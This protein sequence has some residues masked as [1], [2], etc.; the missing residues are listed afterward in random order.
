MSK[1]RTKMITEIPLKAIV[2][3]SDG[4]CGEVATLVF[5]PLNRKLTNVIV[6]VDEMQYLVPIE[7]VVGSTPE[8]ITLDCTI[9]ELTKMELFTETRYIM[10]EMPMN[11]NPAY[12]GGMESSVYYMDPYVTMGQQV[13]VPTEILH[14]P[15]GQKAIFR[16]M[17]VQA[18]D[19]DVGQIGELVIDP[20]EGIITHFTLEQGHVLGTTAVTLPL[21]AVAKVG[22][23]VVFL[24]LSKADINKLPALPLKRSYGVTPEGETIEMVAIRFQTVDKAAEKLK[25]MQELHRRGTFKLINTA[26]FVRDEKGVLSIKESGDM[27][28][29]RGSVFGAITGGLM[30]MI[31]G[32]GGMVAGALVGAG[33]GRGAA[34]RID[35]G[36][37]DEFLKTLGEKLKPGQSAI[38][39]LLEHRWL[40]KYSEYMGDAEEVFTRQTLTDRMV[41]Q[42]LNPPAE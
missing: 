26:I 15:Q 20:K 34:K 33:V 27:G 10:T 38:L 3:C 25:E 7:K 29:K 4:E 14:I 18:T 13:E 8:R 42:L 17:E 16:G 35:V 37:N 2:D 1:E 39:V 21:A 28:P 19:G 31:A 22:S 12:Y 23:E 24:T 5:N 9:E 6:R 36:F 11:Y 41:D 32:P 30:G 40:E